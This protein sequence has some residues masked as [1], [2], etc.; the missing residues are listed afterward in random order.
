MIP[1]V[2]DSLNLQPAWEKISSAIRTVDNHTLVVFEGVTFDNFNFGFT[3]V[4][5]GLAY[6][7][8]SIF[9]Y[10]YYRPP[11]VTSPNAAMILQQ[12]ASK[13]LRCGAMLTEFD[14]GYDG[15]I[16]SLML[17]T[18]RAADSNLVSWMGWAYKSFGNITG[19]PLVAV[20][21]PENGSLVHQMAHILARPYAQ[22]VAGQTVLMKYSD[23]FRRFT[24]KFRLNTGISAPTEILYSQPFNF[25][26]GVKVTAQPD[27]HVRWE[28]VGNS[29]LLIK[30]T[31][32]AVNNELI[33][34][35]LNE[36]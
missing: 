23:S 2:A 29:K 33:V 32:S 10:H 3:Q 19:D 6:A 27:G 18:V 1:G 36:A 14:A 16:M 24:L 25:P 17:E 26:A 34:I 35:T 5:G 13:K 31:P 22:A 9:G 21:Y 8:R 15:N 11:R 7:N 4:P 30:P 28:S 20:V 12:K